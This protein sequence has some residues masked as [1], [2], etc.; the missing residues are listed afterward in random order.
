MKNMNDDSDFRIIIDRYL[1]PEWRQVAEDF[2]H[3]QKEWVHIPTGF[4]EAIMDAC[5]RKTADDIYKAQE[6]E[7][8]E[9]EIDPE[10]ID[11]VCRK[12]IKRI[13]KEIDPDFIGD[14]SD[15]FNS[16]DALAFGYCCLGYSLDELN[17]YLE[18]YIYDLIDDCSEGTPITN[19][20]EVFGRFMEMLDEHSE[21]K[22]IQN[23]WYRY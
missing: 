17:P 10:I 22:K 12:V 14:Y 6:D 15:T 7:P 20:N 1:A 13:K 16:Y 9:E 3:N 19:M 11:K 4:I 21:L 18:R 2:L 23:V 5:E 8:E